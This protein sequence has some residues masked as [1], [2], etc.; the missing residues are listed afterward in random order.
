[1]PL[2]VL[3]ASCVWRAL[4]LALHWRRDVTWT[5]LPLAND[6]ILSSHPRHF[7]T[8]R[9]T[10]LTEIHFRDGPSP[11]HHSYI[12]HRL[13]RRIVS[14]FPSAPSAKLHWFTM[15][16]PSSSIIPLFPSSLPIA[17][18]L[19]HNPP[20]KATS[21][22]TC[23]SPILIRSF[24]PIGPL[25]L[26]YNPTIGYF[27]LIHHKLTSSFDGI[28]FHP[29]DRTHI[30]LSTIKDPPALNYVRDKRRVKGWKARLAHVVD[31]GV[32]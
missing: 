10:R 28:H 23:K 1:M 19:T 21:D 30:P 5:N 15:L 13:S 12:P 7:S 32:G 22:R 3:S 26:N 6:H 20:P 8:P 11:F 24:P 27:P 29:P 31:L 2:P 14:S 25:R 9:T 4:P 17:F 16:Y 18:I